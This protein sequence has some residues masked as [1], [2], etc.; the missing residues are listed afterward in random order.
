[1]RICSMHTYHL[2]YDHPDSESHM[3]H[4]TKVRQKYLDLCLLFDCSNPRKKRGR[5]GGVYNDD[6][7]AYVYTPFSLLS[8]PNSIA[9]SIVKA[10]PR[11]AVE[12]K[13]EISPPF[14]ERSDTSRAR[15]NGRQP[16]SLVRI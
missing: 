9:S 8:Q 14:A 11:N 5:K 1:M 15:A 16:Q 10:V 13:A 4:E 3:K 6:I 7:Q 2:D 12:N